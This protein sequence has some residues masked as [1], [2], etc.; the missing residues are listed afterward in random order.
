MD[1]VHLNSVRRCSDE[2]KIGK[3]NKG[4][5]NVKKKITIEDNVI[6]Q[7]IE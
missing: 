2:I 6:P 7:N 4:N 3:K 5:K 1:V